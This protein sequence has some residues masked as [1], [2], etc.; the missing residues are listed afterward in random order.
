MPRTTET[1]TVEVTKGVVSIAVGVCTL[2]GMLL[3]SMAF[4][5]NKNAKI[6]NA[7]P[8]AMLLEHMRSDTLYHH[9]NEAHHAW[10]DS[11]IM[12]QQRDQHTESE[13]ARALNCYIAN[14]PIGFCD[15][16]R[17]LQRNLLNG[18]KP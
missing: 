2:I 10:Q 7:A 17:Q 12:Q 1:G 13:R 16:V 15:D 11:L 5:M 9:E 6:E 14:N 4:I 8:K 3:T 18:R